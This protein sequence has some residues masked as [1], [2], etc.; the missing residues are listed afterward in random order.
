MEEEKTETPATMAGKRAAKKAIPADGAISWDTIADAGEVDH[1]DEEEEDDSKAQVNPQN[2]FH[3]MNVDEALK[4]SKYE[5]GET[6]IKKFPNG[7]DVTV[8]K[9]QKEGFAN[10]I[11]VLEKEGLGMKV[12]LASNF[13]LAEVRSAVGSR[14][15]LDVM[16]VNTQTN[17]TMTMK[18]WHKY[19]ETPV[20][21]RTDL[22]NVISL[23]FS[24][25]KLDNQVA[26]PRVV[27]QIDWI[28]KVWPRHLKEMQVEATNSIDD[29][30]YPK[31]QKYCLMSVQGCW[32]DFHIDLGGTSVWYHILK[33]KKIFFLI[34]PTDAN[35]RLYENWVISGKQSHTFFG[36]MVDSCSRIELQAGNTFF[37]P[38]GWIHAVFTPED[39]LVFGGNFLHSFSVEKQLQVAHIEEV[40]RVPQKFRFPFFTEMLWYMLDRY[41]HCIYGRTHLDLPEEEKR[42]IKLEKGENIDPNKEFLK[43]TGLASQDHIKS[44]VHLS[45]MELN[46]IKY[47]VMYLH[48]L[49][50]SKKNVPLMLP[51][52]IA[53]IKDIRQ[54]VIDHKDDNPE[55]AV[56][57]KYVLRWTESD[58]VDHPKRPRKSITKT[59][60]PNAGEKKKAN[61]SKTPTPAPMLANLPPTSIPP[62]PN[63]AAP[64]GLPISGDKSPNKKSMA[65]NR[66]RRVRC[67]TCEACQGGDCKLCVYCKDMT[68]YGGPGRMKQT[69]EKVMKELLRVCFFTK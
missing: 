55:M 43:M 61:G 24:Q 3:R 17:L 26:A 33:G 57:G 27:R 39:S 5:L 38:S 36:D 29:M 67:K 62:M 50:A 48:Y 4:S 8:R 32:T 51:D 46:G 65:S 19:Y 12:P 11:C 28:D 6:H 30:M 64:G 23:E 68:K 18:E 52:P 34:P 10:P 45:P 2:A 56:S 63:P 54:L 1:D 40:T 25:T 31:V 35:L 9:F 53:V 69:C 47:A 60:G 14:R 15:L 20:N 7:A 59:M 37:I 13:G 66:R 42:R 22:Y 16:N 58:D 49:P 44:R 21:L 41:V